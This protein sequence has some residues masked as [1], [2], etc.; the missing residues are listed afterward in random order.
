LPVLKRISRPGVKGIK[1]M[2][3]MTDP[4]NLAV[5]NE[6]IAALRKAAD[7]LEAQTTEFPALHRNIRRVSAS[8]KMLELN[9]TDALLLDL[10]PDSGDGKDI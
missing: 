7:F 2:L 9:L 10:M 1:N 8:V 3:D 5:I 6:K 4:R